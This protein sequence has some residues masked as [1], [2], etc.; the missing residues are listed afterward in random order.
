MSSLKEIKEFAKVQKVID[1]MFLLQ[2][3]D[4]EMQTVFMEF[5]NLFIEFDETTK[6]YPSIVLH[7]EAKD[8]F[9]EWAS[10][11]VLNKP[12]EYVKENMV[13]KDVDW[14]LHTILTNARRVYGEIKEYLTEDEY[15]KVIDEVN[16]L[17]GGKKIEKVTS[18]TE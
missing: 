4:P 5:T 10:D 6:G 11:V 14:A 9:F 13:T 12:I 18:V 1:T 3:D 2:K 7:P 16:V 8:R 17:T 15:N